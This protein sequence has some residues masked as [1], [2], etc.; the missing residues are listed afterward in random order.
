MTIVKSPIRKGNDFPNMIFDFK[1]YC[2]FA[3]HKWL[4]FLVYKI[5]SSLKVKRR[6][7][8]K[9]YNFSPVSLS[10][11]IAFTTPLSKGSFLLCTLVPIAMSLRFVIGSGLSVVCSYYVSLYRNK[12]YSNNH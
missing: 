4:N 1:V 9:T 3:L 12:P 10:C 6:L 8:V 11:L 7:L 5:I 2:Y